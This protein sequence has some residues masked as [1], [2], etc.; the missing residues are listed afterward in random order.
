VEYLLILVAWFGCVA[1]S[2]FLL[3]AL[4]LIEAP[5]EDFGDLCSRQTVSAQAG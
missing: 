5:L 2:A 3:C 4:P 1:S